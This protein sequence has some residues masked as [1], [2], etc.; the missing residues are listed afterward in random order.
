MDIPLVKGENKAILVDLKYH[1]DNEAITFYTY[2]TLGMAVLT[3]NVYTER[4]PRCPTPGEDS[5]FKFTG[6]QTDITV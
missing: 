6:L 5:D 2:N 1:L 4:N 3:A